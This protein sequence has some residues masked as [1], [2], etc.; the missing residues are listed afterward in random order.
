MAA[1][2]PLSPRSA[3]AATPRLQHAYPSPSFSRSAR[4][5]API[6]P[7]VR[8]D[9]AY[10]LVCLRHLLVC[11]RSGSTRGA[12]KCMPAAQALYG[13]ALHGTAR[14]GSARHGNAWHGMAQNCIEQHSLA[15]ADMAM[16]GIV[17]HDTGSQRKAFK[18]HRIRRQRTS[19]HG[20]A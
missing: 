7:Q 9:R 16:H 2:Q 19:E 3:G 15:K 6:L 18:K 12:W 11:A 4:P 1:R 17:W 13:T 10:R 5:P 8:D 20:N 14:R